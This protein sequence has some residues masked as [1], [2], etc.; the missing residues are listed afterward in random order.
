MSKA[1]ERSDDLLG[2]WTYFRLATPYPWCWNC[3]KDRQSVP[4]GWAGP[5]L[6]ERAHIVNNPRACDRRAAVLLC[7]WCHRIQHGAQLVLP[8]CEGLV[9][10]V[11]A[12]LW[13]KKEMDPDWYDRQFL[14]KHYVG[15]LPR[16]RRMPGQ[17]AARFRSEG[18][19]YGDR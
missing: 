18:A 15:R 7:S 16:A 17:T 10:D 19:G 8:G 2:D 3:G 9:L 1:W 4:A 14:E 11:P 13:L 12:M 5:W 6:I